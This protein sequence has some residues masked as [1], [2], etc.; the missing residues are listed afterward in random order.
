MRFLKVLIPL[1][2]LAMLAACAKPPQAEVDAAKTALDTAVANP[3]V[4]AYAPSALQA[5]QDRLAQLQSELDAQ[6]AKG[7]LSRK[8][9]EA[10]NMALEAQA[11]AEGL[12]AQAA[13][14]KEQTKADAM[15]LLNELAIAVPEAEKGLAAAKRVRGVALDFKALTASLAQAKTEVSA[16][17]AAYNSGDFATAKAT[18]AAVKDSLAQGQQVVADAVAA[19]KVSK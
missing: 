9:D 4:A 5:A 7:A 1:L 2:V 11:A 17:D 10:K 13:T 12:A 16:A 6:A 18:A 14:A 19:A 15:T 8:Y 3:D